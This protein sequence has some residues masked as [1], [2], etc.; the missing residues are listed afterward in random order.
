[1]PRR[2]SK[3]ACAAA[4]GETDSRGVYND[5]LERLIL[6]NSRQPELVRVVMHAQMAATQM[7]AVAH[8]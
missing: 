8:Y 6:A 1:M 2:Y 4:A 7:G 3:K 5:D